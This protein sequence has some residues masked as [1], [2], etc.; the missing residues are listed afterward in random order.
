MLR[1]ESQS[2]EA[3][4]GRRVA[5]SSWLPSN[6]VLAFTGGRRTGATTGESVTNWSATL[7]QEFEIAGQRGARRRVVDAEVDAQQQR[8]AVR[9]RDIAAFAL[10]TFYDNL[11]AKEEIKLT[12]R[13]EASGVALGAATRG[14]A[15][16]G[17]GVPAEADAAEA[18]ALRLTQ[19]RM[20]AEL[21]F[22]QAN[23]TLATLLGRDPQAGTVAV[24]G[25]LLPLASSALVRTSHERG[26]DERPEVKAL[27]A[28]QRAD[29]ARAEGFRRARIPNVTV[30]ATAQ[31]DGFDE[32]VFGVGVSLPIPLPQPIGRTYAGEIAQLEALSRRGATVA[33]AASR[34]LRLELVTAARA[35]ESRRSERG[36]FTPER[37]ERAE[38]T[39]ADLA[40]EIRGGRLGLRDALITQQALIELLRAELE[41]R[42]ALCVASVELARAANLSL[43]RGL[44]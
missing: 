37:I 38:R 32:R 24:D 34:E 4:A 31:N 29:E 9:A 28:D 15:D 35:Y 26:A 44:P 19:A 12:R 14:R 7:S 2:L 23:G 43:E 3:L 5:V 18:T 42:R 21:R 1:G 41:T 22:A 36:M 30:S 13:L 6:P 11:A 16:I 39:L 20:S 33:E 40:D 25:E 17:V 10:T 8:K 27:V